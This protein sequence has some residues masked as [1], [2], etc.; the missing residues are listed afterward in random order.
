MAGTEKRDISIRGA[1]LLNVGIVGLLLVATVGM[2]LLFG[3]FRARESASQPPPVSLVRAEARP[4]PPEPRLQMSPSLDFRAVR[5]A[6]DQA[7]GGYGWVDRKAGKVRI[8]IERAIDLI[9]ERGLP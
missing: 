6:D 3:Y 5:A 9:A 7:L 8:P 4:L 1:T 2:R